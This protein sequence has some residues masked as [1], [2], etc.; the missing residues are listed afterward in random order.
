M[1]QEDS[2][3]EIAFREIEI[4]ELDK[5]TWAKAFSLSTD[6]EHAKKLYIQYRVEKSKNV[7]EKDAVHRSEPDSR[8]SEI[9][10]GNSTQEEKAENKDPSWLI[11]VVNI[12]LV[13]PPAR[14]LGAWS[15]SSS[16]NYSFDLLEFLTPQLENGLSWLTV[17]WPVALVY[18][19]V[20]RNNIKGMSDVASAK[21]SG[22]AKAKIRKLWLNVVAVGNAGSMSQKYWW[23]YISLLV[24]LFFPTAFVLMSI[25]PRFFTPFDI[26]SFAAILA[27]SCFLAAFTAGIISGVMGWD[28]F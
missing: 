20:K 17:L 5:A 25:W 3:Y 8:S 26:L 28:K 27:T 13:V 24:V 7:Y 4:G 1:D 6:D 23:L 10:E 21:L 14:L 11:L 12:I 15:I 9:E 18:W 22:S 19:L 16:K 2:F